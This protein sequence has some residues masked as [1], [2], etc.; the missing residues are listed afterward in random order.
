M[1]NFF[2]VFSHPVHKKLKQTNKF[3]FCSSFATKTVRRMLRKRLQH[4]LINFIKKNRK[5][6]DIQR[7]F[8]FD[9]I[10]SLYEDSVF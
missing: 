10:L 6:L 2:D 5:I 4:N 8:N 3:Q 1:I 9:R 7:K